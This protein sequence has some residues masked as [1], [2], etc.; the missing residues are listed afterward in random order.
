M[1]VMVT[2][3]YRHNHMPLGHLHTQ[4]SYYI[5]NRFNVIE[6]NGAISFKHEYRGLTLSSPYDVI[7]DVINMKGLIFD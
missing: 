3:F 6:E 5:S 4:F 2:I 7:S 1:S